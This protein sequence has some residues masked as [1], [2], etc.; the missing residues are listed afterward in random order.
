[1]PDSFCKQI[2]PLQLKRRPVYR[3]IFRYI[4]RRAWNTG[5]YRLPDLHILQ[6]DCNTDTTLDYHTEH[7]IILYCYYLLFRPYRK[8]K[9]YP[10][11]YSTS[12][13]HTPTAGIITVSNSVQCQA[14]YLQSE[15]SWNWPGNRAGLQSYQ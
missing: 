12:G 3:I 2:L 4:E 13:V 5:V 9:K 8:Q 10:G 15:S 1:M 6:P 14:T 7:K 11:A